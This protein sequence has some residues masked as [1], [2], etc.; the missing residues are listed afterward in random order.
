MIITQTVLCMIS[1]DIARSINVCIV[2]GNNN[3]VSVRHWLIT[4][5]GHRGTENIHL[6]G[7]IWTSELSDIEKIWNYGYVYIGY[8]GIN[9]ATANY[10]S[11]YI[12]KSDFNHKEFKGK[13]LCS[14]GIGGNNRLSTWA[15]V[16][17]LLGLSIDPTRG[18]RI[19]E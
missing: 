5:L 8:S 18:R 7:I 12:L 6:H 1:N 9:E 3:K 2:N 13:I 17:L 15:L 10:I 16:L 11:K 19:L 14:R 4:E